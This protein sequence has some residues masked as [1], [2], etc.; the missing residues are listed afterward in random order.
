MIAKLSMGNKAPDFKFNTPWEKG[1][2]LSKDASEK[3][4]VLIFLRYQGCPICQMEMANLRRDIDLFKQKDINLYVILQSS[5][6]VVA[7]VA[8]KEDW[9]FAIVCDPLGDIFKLYNVE[10]GGVLKYLHPAGLAAAIKATFKGY[11]HG[12]FEGKETQLPA[13]FTIGLDKKI[14]YAYYGKKIND[15]PSPR[16]LMN[17]ID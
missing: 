8:E 6:E 4:S 16:S 11:M 3:K 10:A 15:V 5:S 9:P 7:S 13:A 1:L 17:N 14:K 2:E 12:K